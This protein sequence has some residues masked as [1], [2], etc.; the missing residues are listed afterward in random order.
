MERASVIFPDISNTNIKAFYG[1]YIEMCRPKNLREMAWV[2]FF[3]GA[4]DCLRRN[5]RIAP[6]DTAKTVGA[7]W[8]YHKKMIEDSGSEDSDSE[9]SDSEDS[10]SEDSGS[11][12]SDSE[13]PRLAGNPM[14][15][16]K[17]VPNNSYTKKMREISDLYNQFIY[18]CKCWKKDESKLFELSYFLN[19]FTE[20]EENQQR[21]LLRKYGHPLENLWLFH[22]YKCATGRALYSPY[23]ACSVDDALFSLDT[24]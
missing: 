15:D 24:N 23:A 11:E 8:H 20:Y 10:G 5:T 1:G 22:L 16:W 21:I 19:C 4:Y 17:I 2:D 7:M 12:D 6:K 13:D 18:W 14:K 3:V 9:D